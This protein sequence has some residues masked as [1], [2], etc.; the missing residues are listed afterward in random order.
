MLVDGVSGADGE[1]HIFVQKPDGKLAGPFDSA[2]KLEVVDFEVVDGN[3]DEILEFGEDIVLRNIRVQNSG[4][5]TIDLSLMVGGTPSPSASQVTMEGDSTEWL[6]APRTTHMVPKSILNGAA[7]MIDGKFTFRVKRPRDIPVGRPFSVEDV[8]K[9][10]GHMSGIDRAI[11]DF[12]SARKITLQHPIE[13]TKPRFLRCLTVGQ[14]A[15]FSWKV[16]SCAG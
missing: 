15:V 7:V 3:E 1:A 2:Y 9:L 12:H 10:R 11:P 6:I 4:S 13:M 5:M 14:E 8:F 16:C